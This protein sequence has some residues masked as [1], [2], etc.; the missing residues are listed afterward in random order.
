MT[1]LV[2]IPPPAKEMAATTTILR[3]TKPKLQTYSG[4]LGVS[5]TRTHGLTIING[6]TFPQRLFLYSSRRR[7]LAVV[8]AGP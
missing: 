8:Y 6:V 4:N 3:G 1:A 2:Q 7:S 5:A